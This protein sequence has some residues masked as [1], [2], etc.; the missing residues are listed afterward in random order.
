MIRLY[1]FELSEGMVLAEP[2]FDGT[3]NNLLL[4][5][6]TVLTESHI[7][8]IKKW[9]I[10]SV[11]VT[12]R[13]TLL[14][15]P[16]SSLVKELKK[17]LITEITRLAPEKE[18][19]NTSDFMLTVSQV[20]CQT[21]LK[22]LDN[23]VVLDSLMRI[24][25]VDDD[26]L[27]PHSVETCALSLLV[28][29]SFGVDE[30]ELFHIGMAA[31]LH[32]IGLC[33]MPQ[34]INMAEMQLHQENLWKEHSLYGY[35]LTKESGLPQEVCKYILHH[36]ESWNGEGYPKNLSG[37]A[38]PFGSRIIAVCEQYNRKLRQE[39]IP[40]YLA[41]E[42]LYG[43]G[44]FYFDP[45]VVQAFT[46]NLAVYP[47]GSLVR[48]STGQVGVVINVRQNLGPR[49]IVRIYYNRVNMPLRVPMDMDLAKDRTVFIEQVL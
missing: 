20:A 29:G 44:G 39:K 6:G 5:Y 41:I 21:A 4:N 13:Y 14:I 31:L 33:E 45:H 27:L 15:E 3:T 32:D 34:L 48:L 28:A 26:F 9:G 23:S 46:N 10:R 25:L 36:H 7:A 1:S 17:G 16:T 43:G 24:K 47:L 19:A 38:I 35:Y 22:L 12:E 8:A 49:P 40:H 11:A 18:E 2:L 42:Y 37:E 30:K